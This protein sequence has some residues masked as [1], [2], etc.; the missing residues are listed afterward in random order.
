MNSNTE[1]APDSG[2]NGVFRLADWQVDPRILRISSGDRELKLE[3][4]VMQVL[5]FLVRNAGQVVTREELERNVWTGRVVG[6]DAVANTVIKLRKAFGDDSR[7]PRIIETIPKIGYRLIAEVEPL[8]AAPEP[9]PVPLRAAGGRAVRKPLTIAAVLLGILVL[10]L[11]ASLR[12]WTDTPPRAASLVEQDAK[13]LA[14]LPSI[15]VLPFE[16]LD[17]DESQ[18]YFSDGITEDLITDLSKVPGLLV[19][20]RNSVFA[21]QG[22]AEAEPTI[23]QALGARYLLKGSVRRERDRVRI[24]VRLVDATQGRNLWAERYDQKLTSL[25]EIQDRLAASIVT[26]LRVELE[27]QTRHRL[28]R[29]YVTSIE[30]YDEFLRGVDFYG[31][32]SEADIDEAATHFEAAIR[33]DPSFARAYSGLALTRIRALSDGWGGGDLSILEDAQR[34]VDRAFAIDDGVPQL[35][36]V[37]SQIEM[38]RGNLPQALRIIERAL[39]LKPSYADGYAGMAWILHFAG[40][41][42]EGLKV[43]TVAE[44]L[45]PSRPS[46]YR[47]VRGASLY[48]DQSYR[49]AVSVLETAAE[50]SPHHPLIRLWLT[51]AYAGAERRW[52]VEW[53]AAE[54]QSLLPD[55]TL[56]YVKAAF[57]IKDPDYL[58][59]FIHHLEQA[60]LKD[61]AAPGTP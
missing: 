13:E 57:P 12:T 16:N 53:Q 9:G 33:L 42:K 31:R 5:V 43:I 3:P 39:D 10:V 32:R 40:R 46:I 58:A 17:P 36:F 23:G 6:Y 8:A 56:D 29:S 27:P 44:R 11:A 59:R 37:R 25:F 7:Q 28:V 20:A 54:L 38:Y 49:E 55:F 1:P 50:I 22:S 45:N 60:G 15:A 21:Y 61:T 18:Q 19:V 34:L 41:P 4:R 47:L 14:K 2:F 26:A 52:D 24:N 30:A 48:A 51:A 35:Y